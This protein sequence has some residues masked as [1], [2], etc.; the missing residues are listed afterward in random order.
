M[1]TFSINEESFAATGYVTSCT[2]GKPWLTLVHGWNSD[3]DVWAGLGERLNAKY[4][5]L[6]PNLPG[7][8][9]CKR[10][11]PCDFGSDSKY[12]Y[13]LHEKYNIDKLFIAG[14]SYGATLSPLR[15]EVSG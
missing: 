11:D 13:T 3:A 4:N 10:S 7:F 9:G 15:I 5:I 12:I 8:G 1:D 2:S 14:H 6:I